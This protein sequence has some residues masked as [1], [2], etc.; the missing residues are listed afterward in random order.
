VINKNRIIM[1]TLL[2]SLRR[3]LGA[4]ALLATLPTLAQSPCGLI[5]VTPPRYDALDPDLLVV[6]VEN[7]SSELFSYPSF[8]LVNDQGDTL[9]SEQ[10]STFGIGGGPEPRY[11]QVTPGVT[12]PT[13]PFDATLLLFS[14][15]GD[16]LFCTWDFPGLTL[17]PPDSC[18]QAEIHLTNT[19][20][21]TPFSA[22]WWV[23]DVSDGTWVA[24]GIID[25]DDVTATHFDTLCLP[26]GAYVLEFSPFSPIDSNYISGI[27]WNS[28]FTMGT[29]TQLQQEGTPLDL[30]FTWYEAC[31]DGSGT[32]SIEEQDAVQPMV[33][34][35]RNNLRIEDPLGRPLGDISVWSLDGRLIDRRSSSADRAELPLNDLPPGILLVRV[36]APDGRIFTQRVLTL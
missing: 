19:G 13:G 34:M 27:T 28:Q 10:V 35:D 4:I 2:P 24:Q 7:Q 20:V 32:N 3:S 17:C 23:A 30:A 15:F 29:S 26:P 33:V 11:M 18:V 16:T 1:C 6:M 8:V 21:L 9:A 25:M 36:A 22:Y 14:G 5:T 12:L 31:V